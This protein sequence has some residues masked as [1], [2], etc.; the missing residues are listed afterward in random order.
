MRER[1]GRYEEVP[2]DNLWEK[3]ATQKKSKERAWP[4]WV[5]TISMVGMGVILL[6]NFELQKTVVE[7]PVSVEKE[8][9]QLSRKDAQSETRKVTQS[10][11]TTDTQTITRNPQLETRNSKLETPTPSIS[12]LKSEI[13]ADS[14][15]PP[16]ITK[17]DSSDVNEIK[18]VE[19]VPP[20]KKPKSKFQLY[21]SLTPSLSF[22]KMIPSPNE[23]IIIEGFQHRST[24]SMKRFGFGI[25]AG[26]Q[27]DINKIFG[28]YG[29]LSFYR[30]HQELTYRYF[31][32]EADVTR[33]GDE[34]TF[35][36]NRPQHTRTFNYSMTNVGARTGLLITLKGEKLK[37]KFGAGIAYSYGLMTSQ[38]S[39]TN[40]ASNY[41][42]YQVF[43]RN[44]VK[45]NDRWSWFV[46]PVFTYSFMSKE[47]LTEP[48]QLKPYR[49]G[50]SVGTLYRF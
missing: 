48:F 31:D 18:D 14:I 1:L 30:Q 50:V 32:R 35:E 16:V 24:M 44:E 15:S 41:L 12:D 2:S 37:H 9:M 45:V 20:Y 34:W 10:E 27:K 8:Q 7:K 23:Q 28:F 4:V 3:I 22:Q 49:A 5:Q 26:F 6:L 47:K 19:I 38:G 21:F 42:A 36:I 39:Y 43:Y 29:G 25:D 33:V 40:R 17:K 11:I 46:E 13:T